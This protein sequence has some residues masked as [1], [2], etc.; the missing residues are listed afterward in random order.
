MSEHSFQTLP[1]DLMSPEMKDYIRAGHQKHYEIFTRVLGNSPEACPYCC[2]GGEIDLIWKTSYGSQVELRT[3]PCPACGSPA[4]LE[5][6]WAETGLRECERSWSINFI[7][8]MPGKEVACR[9]AGDLVSHIQ[10]AAG[11]VAFFG[12]YGVGKTGL[13][14]SIVAAATCCRRPAR[15]LHAEHMLGLI[16]STYD[17]DSPQKESSLADSFATIPI[18]ALDEV[19]RVSTSNWAMGQLMSI[20]DRRYEARTE[21]LTLLATNAHID[22][23]P[24]PFRY[25]QSRL[26]DGQRIPVGG[27]DLRGRGS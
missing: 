5:D 23:L 16:R 20:L 14:K 18:L 13:L 25:L 4:R 7:Q 3:F 24:D 11:L 19:D 9:V 17:D 15:Y 6:V 27:V 10:N 1:P 12:S 2:G 8:N 22:R 26:R 21:L